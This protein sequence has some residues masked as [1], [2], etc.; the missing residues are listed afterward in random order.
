MNPILRIKNHGITTSGELV[1]YPKVLEG[2]R[3]LMQLKDLQ[4]YMSGRVYFTES[5]RGVIITNNYATGTGV[6]I[7]D[8]LNEGEIYTISFKQRLIEGTYHNAVAGSIRLL[9]GEENIIF[10]GRDSKEVSITFTAPLAKDNYRLYFYGSTAGSIEFYDMKIEKGSKSTTWTP[11]PEDIGLVYPD[12]VQSFSTSLSENGIVAGEIIEDNLISFDGYDLK[13][14]NFIEGDSIIDDNSGSPGSKDLM[15]GDMSAGYFGKV[16]ANELFT[17]DEIA[18]LCEVTDGVSQ[19]SNT[20]WLKL[21]IDEKIIF[22]PIKPIRTHISW[23]HLEDMDCIYGNKT[24]TKN[25]IT[26]KV[27]LMKGAN[28][29]PA[30]GTGGGVVR[31]SEWNRLLLPLSINAKTQEWTHVDNIDIPTDYWGTDFTNDDLIDGRFVWCQEVAQNRSYRI[32]RGYAAIEM[33]SGVVPRLETYAYS[34]CPALEVVK[35]GD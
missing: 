29:D 15:A 23:N 7:S 30:G 31:Y 21:V 34:W 3:N 8:M 19:F 6:M 17:G 24:V 1:E 2:G 33:S 9:G 5:D 13:M 14:N 10:G 26:Y 18:N 12:W 22:R 28:Q 27:R 20:D 32:V 16:K 11:S 4:E 25:G 35:G